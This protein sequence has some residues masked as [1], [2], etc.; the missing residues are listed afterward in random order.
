MEWDESKHPR[1]RSGKFTDGTADYKYPQ[2][3]A[4]MNGHEGREK[5]G[6]ELSPQ[7]Y[8][9]L[10]AEVMRKNIAQSGKV[11]PTNFAF[12]S[13]YFYMFRY[14]KSQERIVCTL[15]IPI[16]GNEEEIEYL[17]RGKHGKS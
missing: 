16:E 5:N 3:L 9:A 17:M 14:T 4:R 11:K 12:T 15:R 13:N 1:D 8:G 7:E 6:I 2:Y 10:R